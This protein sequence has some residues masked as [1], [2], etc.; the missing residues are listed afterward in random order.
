MNDW[1][2]DW[3]AAPLPGEKRKRADVTAAQFR[4]LA[5][6]RLPCGLFTLTL[7]DGSRRTFRVRLERGKFCT[8]QRT[9][10]ISRKLSDGTIDDPAKEW[11]SLAVVSETGFNVFKRWRGQ[12][13][14]RWAIALWNLVHGQEMTGYSL[15]VEPKCWMTGRQL[16]T[17]AHRQVG[18]C[19]TWKKRF[20]L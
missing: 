2:Q 13:E 10:S 9:L 5:A 4:A 7:T 14:E 16:K 19:E 20:G 11:E 3:E 17:D 12:W 8:G 18:L 6:R 15:D 1:D